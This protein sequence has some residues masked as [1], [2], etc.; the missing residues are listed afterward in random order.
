M[1]LENSFFISVNGLFDFDFTF[2][3]EALLFFIL[4]TAVTNFFLLPISKQI[5]ERNTYINYNINKVNIIVGLTSEKFQESID[6]FLLQIDELIRQT[7]L[8]KNYTKKKFEK[9]VQK[10]E[11]ENK[12]L[13]NKVK[14]SLIFESA[15]NFKTLN[16]KLNQIADS[17]LIEKFNFE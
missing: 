15:E 6:I 8:V 12:S 17:F 2:L 7:N 1:S 5:E 16:I 4:S 14:A 9:E 13:L 11:A 3:T 10:I